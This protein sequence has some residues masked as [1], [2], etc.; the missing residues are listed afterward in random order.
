MFPALQSPQIT[1]KHPAL[2]RP[3]HKSTKR[4]TDQNRPVGMIEPR[5]TM[6]TI[7]HFTSG[8]TARY[9]HPAPTSISIEWARTDWCFNPGNLKK[10][11]D[12]GPK[13]REIGWTDHWTDGLFFFFVLSFKSS[14]RSREDTTLTDRSFK[15]PT[16]RHG[17]TVQ[18]LPPPGWVSSSCDGMSQNF[19]WPVI[20]IWFG[21]FRVVINYGYR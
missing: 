5:K 6:L 16:T 7:K 9:E 1:R 10:V 8:D 18:T 2:D 3:R 14:S 21:T 12:T 17:D 15:T 20:V 4:K 19:F 11:T 13:R